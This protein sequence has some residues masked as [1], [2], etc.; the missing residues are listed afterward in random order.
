[1]YYFAVPD[2]VEHHVDLHSEEVKQTLHDIDQ[3]I[4]Y[5]VDKTKS[6]PTLNN[7]LNMIFL[8]DHGHIN[9]NP[10]K[11][12][13]HMQ[14]YLDSDVSSNIQFAYHSLYRKPGSN[15]TI[16]W[17]EVYANLTKSKHKHFKTY[18]RKDIPERYRLK[19][20]PY[21]GEV[22]VVPRAGWYLNFQ[23]KQHFNLTHQ[24]ATT[25]GAHGYTTDSKEMRATFIAYGPDVVKVK[26]DSF[27]NVNVFGII[28]RLLGL[29]APENN[30]TGFL[31]QILKDQV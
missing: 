25:H 3:A 6:S 10:L 11:L 21:I 31:D 28:C 16:D 24:N 23:S 8:S 7:R 13:V 12:V 15:I 30:G 26:L 19:N 14:K 2:E 27:E 5:L 4:G 20:A 22:L 1:M 17:N 29:K 9:T 18:L